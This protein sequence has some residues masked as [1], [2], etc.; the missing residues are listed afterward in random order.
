MV[1]ME[2]VDSSNIEMVGYDPEEME[3]YVKFR[4]CEEPYVYE[5]VPEQ[6]HEEFMAAPSKGSYL[7]RVL[8]GVY[9]FHR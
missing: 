8:K 5:G 2:Y 9:N 4:S 1:D 7:N 3:L 6:V